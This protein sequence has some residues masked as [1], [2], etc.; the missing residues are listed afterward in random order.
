MKR[1]IVFLVF[2]AFL[3]SA[4]F[5]QNSERVIALQG[6]WKFSVGD[7]MEWAQENYN[8]QDWESI[9]VPSPWEDQGF[10]GYDGFAWY[11]KTFVIPGQ[12]KNKAFYINL[13]YIDDCDEVYFNGNLIGLSGSFPPRFSTAYDAF[14][15]YTIPAQYIKFEKSNVIAVRV[16]DAQLAGGIVNG[17]VGIYTESNPFPLEIDLQGMWKFRTGDNIDYK[18][19]N[20]NDNNWRSIIVPKFW[21]EQGYP[22]YDGYA[23]YRK[24]F[25]VQGSYDNERIVVVLGKIDDEDEVYLNGEYIGPAK[26]IVEYL[27]EGGTRYNEFRVFYISGKI[28]HSNKDNIIAVRVYDSGGNGGIYEGPVGIVKQKDFVNYWKNKR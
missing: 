3:Y 4:I 22:D 9:H 2:V 24:K 26:R 18:D 17:D 12:F 15:K 5:A 19:Q 10:Y 14:R 1:L 21:E 16:Y 28:L 7:K 20:Y 13:G 8:D 25:F 11:R 23:W 27:N 6:K